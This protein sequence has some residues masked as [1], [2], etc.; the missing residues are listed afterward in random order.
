MYTGCCEIELQ[1]LSVNPIICTLF[2]F[3][4]THSGSNYDE[5]YCTN[6]QYTIELCHSIEYF[7][8]LKQIML[9][10]INDILGILYLHKAHP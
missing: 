10:T 4:I 1:S 9:K 7:D 5:Q 6:A 3:L 8:D 2:G